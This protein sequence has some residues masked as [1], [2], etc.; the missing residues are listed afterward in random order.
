MI[1]IPVIY[2]DYCHVVVHIYL[3]QNITYNNALPF[4]RNKSYSAYNSKQFIYAHI[5]V[6]CLCSI[7]VH[8]FNILSTRFFAEFYGQNENS[9][10]DSFMCTNIEYCTFFNHTHIKPIK[11]F[12]AKT[13]STVNQKFLRFMA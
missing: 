5:Y 9:R 8:V 10:F 4:S 1:N 2:V 13:M 3:V 11:N 12:K 6:F 7:H